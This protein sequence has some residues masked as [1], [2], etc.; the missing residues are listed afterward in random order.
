MARL[1]L[2]D[3]ERKLSNSHIAD[4]VNKFEALLDYNMTRDPLPPK[5]LWFYKGCI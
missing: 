4:T 5:N 2:G 3:T 1:G